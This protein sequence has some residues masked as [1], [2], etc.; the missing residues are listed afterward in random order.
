MPYSE[1][2]KDLYSLN[3]KNATIHRKMGRIEK[4]WADTSKKWSKWPLNLWKGIALYYSLVKRKLKPQYN[5]VIGSQLVSALI[6]V[7]LQG[8]QHIWD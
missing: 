8:N 2:V 1:Y 7:L 5:T 6:L 4:T 3:K